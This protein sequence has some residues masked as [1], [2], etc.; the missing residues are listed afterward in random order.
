MNLSP[1]IKI[2]RAMD[3]K[4]AGTSD[5][6]S[7]IIDMS[8]FDGVMFIA[9]F[10]EITAGAVT[11]IKAQ[12]GAASNMSDAADLEGSGIDIADDDD[13]KVAVLDIFWRWVNGDAL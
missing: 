13:N 8:G 2:T 4:V 12:Q 10:G 9:A 6:N 11:S 7:N 3:A 5:Q 1:N